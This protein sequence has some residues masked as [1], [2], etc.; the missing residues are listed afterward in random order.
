MKKLTLCI[1]LIICTLAP[2]LATSGLLRAAKFADQK[3]SKA[4]LTSEDS[5][6][7]SWSRFDIDSRMGKPNSSKAEL[8]AFAGK[9]ALD[10]T[11]EETD[12]IESVLKLLDERLTQNNLKIPLPNE[13]FLVRTSG[14]EEGGA[15]AYT[16]AN[17]IVFKANIVTSLPEEDLLR[18]ISH[19]LFHILS[20]NNEHFRK[21]MYSIIGF[22]LMDPVSYPESLQEFRITNPDATQTDSYIR[23]EAAGNAITCMMV[24]YA[25]KKY[26]GGNLFGYLKIGFLQLD[27]SYLKP[28]QLKGKPI[29]YSF[30]EVDGFFEQVGKNTHYLVHPEEILAD[31]F[32][33][34]LSAAPDLP[35]PWVVERIMKVLQE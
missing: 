3:K 9:Q 29:L 1:L 13:I 12:R 20:R 23:L 18:L 21:E 32:A 33:F 8:L 35:D 6:T 24:L 5:F 10:W 25:E 15:S 28:L 14:K 16:R 11:K 26:E 7:K 27:P 31:N 30:R 2:S 17:Y 22:E 4:L 34:A 19:E